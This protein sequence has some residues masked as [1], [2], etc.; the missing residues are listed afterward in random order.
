[1][2]TKTKHSK[3]KLPQGYTDKMLKMLK[4]YMFYKATKLLMLRSCNKKGKQSLLW[5]E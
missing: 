2:Y 5:T 1:M 3:V 4:C